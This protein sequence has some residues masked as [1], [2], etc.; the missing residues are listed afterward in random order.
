MSTDENHQQE[1]LARLKRMGIDARLMKGGRCVLASMTIHNEPFPSLTGPL[2]IERVVFSTVG[3]DRIKCLRPRPLFQ[4]PL[5]RILECEDAQAIEMIIR[6][7]WQS[8]QAELERAQRWLE[9]IGT[10]AEIIEQGSVLRFTI[11][12]EE[13]AARACM[14]QPQQV[15]LPSRGP[16][17]G[18]TLP[19]AQD[20]LL[21]IDVS[22]T[23]SIDLEINISTRL[24]E[25]ARREKIASETR[26]R[27]SVADLEP[28]QETLRTP[29]ILLVGPHLSQ[30]RASIESLRLRGYEVETAISQSEAID[31]FDR[32]SPE[33][34]L[35]DIDMGRSDG[36]EL[37]PSL[38]SIPGVEELPVVLI[39]RHRRPRR[40]EAARS[41]GAAG[42][43][44]YPLEV[45]RIAKRLARMV[46]DPRKRRFT[47]YIQRLSVRIEGSSNPC[48][49][50]ALGRGGMFIV[51][52]HEIRYHT[53]ADCELL[54]PE[55][56]RTLHVQS[57]VLYRSGDPGATHRGIGVRFHNFA[58]EDEPVLIR[59]LRDLEKAEADL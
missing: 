3:R 32:G 48:L 37:I 6:S 26:R 53:L 22:V 27:A 5:L 56:G 38:R 50:T 2:P 54:L 41:L 1:F 43:L 46:E 28:P 44:T 39:D 8:Q 4:L 15:I 40:L 36:I 7:A 59:Y 52:N 9:S 47:R 17:S 25:L 58:E 49:A 45:P 12:G 14:L 21:D 31:A 33:L 34:L 10:R 23:S 18:V 51:T 35:V 55:F 13:R 42:Y 29:R 20:R 30:Q 57:E 11:E 19:A 16:L 24:E